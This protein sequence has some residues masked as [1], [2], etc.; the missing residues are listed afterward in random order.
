MI[1]KHKK[2]QCKECR[3]NLSTFMELMKHI[4]KHHCKDQTEEEE[5]NQQTEKQDY[6][7]DEKVSSFVFNESML[8]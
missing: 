6:K 7:G 5:F 4:A 8:D 3:L 2:H 1:A